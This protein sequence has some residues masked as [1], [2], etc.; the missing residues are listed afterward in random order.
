MAGPDDEWID[1]ILKRATE[2]RAAGVLT[3]SIGTCSATLA[4][5]TP[6]GAGRSAKKKL[7][8]DESY[9]GVFEDPASYPGG[10]VPGYKITPLNSGED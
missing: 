10:V 4:P 7:D 8:D 3:I 9:P 2:L 5:P 6:E 1:I